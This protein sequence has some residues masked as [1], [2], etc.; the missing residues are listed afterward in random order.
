MSRAPLLA[1]TDSGLYCEI[2]DFYIDPWEPV[3]RAVIT[4]AHSDHARL[5]ARSYLAARGNEQLLHTRL[6]VDA[7][8]ETIGYGESVNVDG[9]NV[10]FHPAGHILGSA[11]VRVEYRGEIWV[12]SGDYKIEPDPTCA[13]FEPVRCHTF[14]TEATYGLPIYRWPRSDDVFNQ[15]NN[16]W[17]ANQLKGKASLIYCYALGKAQRILAGVDD[18]IGPIYTHGAVE[19][20]TQDYRE[21]GVQL[22]PTTLANAVP[23]RKTDWSRALILAPP[24]ASGTPWLRRFGAIA[25][26]FASGW[27][28]VRGMRRRKAIDRG[29]IL[30]DHSDWTSL[31]TAIVESHAAKILV[32]H[33]YV[34]IFVRYLQECGID[35]GAIATKFEG[36]HIEENPE[37]EGS[38][39]S[40]NAAEDSTSA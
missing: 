2:G 25:T 8:V 13:A 20:L 1:V 31:L 21:A 11:Q 34:P 7:P 17:R 39:L 18:S 9:V 35:S 14:I 24:S 30:S 28:S 12:V 38:L 15:I 4:H 22:P 27:M 36:E 19:R 3:S 40:L 26:G 33:G 29:F 5:G 6:G 32:T 37:P 16:W 10:S 23:P